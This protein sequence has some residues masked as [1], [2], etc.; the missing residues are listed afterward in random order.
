[1]VLIPELYAITTLYPGKRGPKRKSG[2]SSFSFGHKLDFL[3]LEVIPVVL[4]AGG[5]TALN[6]ASYVYTYSIKGS[7][8]EAYSRQILN[9]LGRLQGYSD[10]SG[11]QVVVWSI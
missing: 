7:F 6:S 4:T 11:S 10:R 9:N 8:W 5:H 3:I 2:T 1:V